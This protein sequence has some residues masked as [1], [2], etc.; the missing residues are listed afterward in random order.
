[1]KDSVRYRYYVSAALVQG[2][3]SNAGSVRRVAAQ[4]M[5]Y[6]VA[7]ALRENGLIDHADATRARLFTLSWTGSRLRPPR[8]SLL[9]AAKLAIA[10][11]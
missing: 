9:C 1:M 10:S 2:N 11:T 4:D 3:K 6:R 8:S 5:E 7:T